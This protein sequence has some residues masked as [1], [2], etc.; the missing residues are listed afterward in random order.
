MVMKNDLPKT[1]N[2]ILTE[3][4]SRINVKVESVDLSNYVFDDKYIWTESEQDDFRDWLADYLYNSPVARKELM[5][6][7]W[8]TKKHCKRVADEFVFMYG[9]KCK[10]DERE[11]KQV[12]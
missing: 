10:Y 8:K 3:M 11:N 9:L 6:I 5:N 7:N 1:L 12:S 2:V 4:F